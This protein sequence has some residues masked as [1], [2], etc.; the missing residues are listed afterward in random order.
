MRLLKKALAKVR[1]EIAKP[2]EWAQTN[3]IESYC[4]VK[5]RIDA[6]IEEIENDKKL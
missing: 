5:K 2:L 1:D 4:K 6:A 3:L